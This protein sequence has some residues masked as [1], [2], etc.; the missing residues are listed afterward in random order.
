MKGTAGLLLLVRIQC[1][2]AALLFTISSGLLTAE[3]QDNAVQDA[4]AALEGGDLTTA[5][6]VLRSHL[7]SRPNDI[8][9]LDVFAVVL[10]KEQNYRE[11]DA[12]YRRAMRVSSPSPGLLNNFGNHL[13][14]TGELKEART[15]FQ[16]VLALD[17]AQANALFQMARLSLAQQS[18]SAALTLL[19][20]LPRDRQAS[21]DVALLRMQALYFAH[22]DREADAILARLSSSA[23]KNAHFSFAVGQALSA[24]KH[25]QK[26]ETF[27]QQALE[28]ASNDFEVLH[29][30]GI[31]ASKAG[32]QARARDIL[33]NAIEQQPK[34]VDALYDLAVVNL[35]LDHKE[36]AL[37]ELGRASELDPKRTDILGLLAHTTAELGYF[38]DA[39][40]AWNR[41]IALAPNDDAG[42]RE[43]GFA[44]SALGNAGSSGLDDLEWFVRKHPEDPIGHYELGVAVSTADSTRSLAQFNR[45]IALRPGYVPALV[46][47]A[48]V[49]YREGKPEAALPDFELAAKLNPNDARVLDHLGQTYLTLDRPTDAARVLRKAADLAP[50][51]SS[52]LIH[53]SR[54]LTKL[55]DKVQAAA[56]IAQVREIGPNKANT[57]HPAGLLAFLALSPEEQYARYRAGVERAVQESPGDAAAQV[58]YLRVL[59]DEGRFDEAATVS[60]QLIVSTTSANLLA[61]AANALIQ[62]KQCPAAKTFVEQALAV[63]GPVPDL[64]LD[65]SLASAHCG[66]VQAGLE[67]LARVPS[68]QRNTNYYL[69]SIVLLTN[70][71][72]FADATAA[73]DAALH[74]ASNR[75][76]LYRSAV[77]SMMA[78]GRTGEALP[79][80]EHGL[81]VFPDDDE[82]LQLEARAL[83]AVSNT[84]YKQQP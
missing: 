69:T 40:A 47:R 82:L 45:A 59:L 46:A 50:K 71:G 72:K 36:Q 61:E 20:R 11:A 57:T 74:T 49:N 29:N 54:A 84:E 44:E 68:A 63:A 1:L 12:V 77:E 27:F 66:D 52:T 80:L 13:L 9:A 55:G 51:D 53:L 6:R 32:D 60:R 73:L 2:A 48:L 10:D 28:A 30:L 42:R 56:V 67:Q 43:R 15:V 26:A 22:R 70:A 19:N 65:L 35:K 25:Y 31:V 16:R 34:N 37:D 64:E 81:R 21:P 8:G 38:G 7:G 39:V 24:A 17:P 78:N 33:Q 79:L 4:V 83:N 58:Q 5:E 62:A 76:D 75:P 3:A 41:Y 14:A 18:G 23:E